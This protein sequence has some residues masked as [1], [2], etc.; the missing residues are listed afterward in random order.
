MRN[1]ERGQLA[2]GNLT[3]PRLGDS[4]GFFNHGRTEHLR[5]SA[6]PEVFVPIQPNFSEHDLF[7][8][9]SENGAQG[10]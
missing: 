2:S 8:V 5:D 1:S 4:S 7:S 6:A 3:E 9:L 10:V